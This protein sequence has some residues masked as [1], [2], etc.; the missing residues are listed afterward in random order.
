MGNLLFLLI[1]ITLSAIGI[2]IVWV[3]HRGPSGVTHG[4]DSFNEQMRAIA[5]DQPPPPGTPPPGAGH[6]MVTRP[7][8]PPTS[9]PDR[10]APKG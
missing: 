3:R 6:T 7:T 2:F 10:P 8:N 9:G 5:P 4:V 1:A